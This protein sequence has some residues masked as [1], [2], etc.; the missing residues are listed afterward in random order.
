MILLKPDQS[1][2]SFSVITA[3]C[4]KYRRYRSLKPCPRLYREL[5][6]K[7]GD[8]EMPFSDCELKFGDV[9]RAL[10]HIFV[11]NVLVGTVRQKRCFPL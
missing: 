11:F 3:V 1:L 6:L 2:P 5:V 10:G 8:Q 9:L 7:S 4:I